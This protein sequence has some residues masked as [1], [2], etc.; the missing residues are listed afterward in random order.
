MR[1]TNLL[2][3]LGVVFA[4]L[5]NILVTSSANSENMM[6]P[7]DACV[8][9][10]PADNFN[11]LTVFG[12]AARA[13]T[14]REDSMQIIFFRFPADLAEPVSISIFDPDAG[15][16]YD[17]GSSQARCRTR[18]R[19]MGGQGAFSD[20]E[21]R[22]AHPRPEQPGVV[23]ADVSFDREYDNKWYSFGPFPA[24]DGELVGGYRYFKVFVHAVSGRQNNSFRLAAWPNTAEA[25]SYNW[26]FNLNREKG[27]IMHL[28]P[29]IP[30]GV[31]KVVMWSYDLDEGGGM[32]NLRTPWEDFAVPGSRSG[33]WKDRS[34]EVPVGEGGGRWDLEIVKG[35]QV[36]ANASFV[37]VDGDGNGLPIFT[38]GEMKREKPMPPPP[39]IVEAPP[40][41]VECQTF[42]FDGAKSYDPD[43]DNLEY[44]WDFGDGTTSS[45][46]RADHTFPG[47]GVYEV[48]LTVNDYSGGKCSTSKSKRMVRV[49][50]PPIAVA[51]VPGKGCVGEG[52]SLVAS[53]STDT[54]GDT[55]S[56]EWDFGDGTTGKGAKVSHS[57][58]KPGNYP[59]TLTVKDDS[60]TPCNTDF[61]QG[62]VSI[63]SAPLADAG[64]DQVI[65]IQPGETQAVVLFDGSKSYDEQGDVLSYKWN[66]GDNTEGQGMNPTHSYAQPG[67]YAVTLEVTDNS[68]TKCNKDTDKMQVKVNAPPKAVAV[69]PRSGCVG[70]ALKFDGSGSSD[71]PGD[72][73]TFTWDFGDGATATGPV[74][75]HSYDTGGVH[76]VVLTVTDSSGTECNYDVYESEVAINAPPVAQAG[77]NITMVMD[78]PDADLWVSFDGSGST[79]SDGNTLTYLWDFGD[80]SQGNGATVSHKYKTGGVYAVT[81]TVFDDSASAC[82][83]SVDK[84]QVRLN[85]APKAVAGKDRDVCLTEPVTLHAYKSYDKDGDALTYTWDLGDG[86]TADGRVVTHNYA[87]GGVYD[88][89]LTVDDGKGD[90]VSTAVDTL[91]VRVNSGPTARID[92]PSMA[93]AGQ[94]VTFDGS[95]SSDPEGDALTYRWDLGDGFT[96]SGARVAHAYDRGGT[97]SVQLSVNDG[98]G[99][100][101]SESGAK[102]SIKVNSAPIAI[103]G[104]DVICCAGDVNQ[105]DVSGSYDPDGDTLTYLWDFGDGKTS[106]EQKPKHTYE[107]GG[108]YTVTLTVTDGTDTAC[109][110]GK[111]SFTVDVNELPV[112]VIEV[113]M[114]K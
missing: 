34:I 92:G 43:N 31:S 91:S 49:N 17:Q 97:Y 94:K 55:L 28:W 81:L 4:L 40:K 111:D 6:G 18:V 41:V 65:C 7:A 54:P 57:Y 82:N 84:T 29:E 36:V 96:A 62:T 5:I 47:P 113:E 74:V 16:N 50:V 11:F 44:L 95:G 67:V 109:N 45:E 33:Q 58:S 98:S 32:L 61:A 106:T 59:I 83:K 71:T 42:A 102:T 72:D 60:G 104:H 112:S 66:F 48:V 64:E 12:P 2:R 38:S 76:P 53:A 25:F 19:I 24:S 85:R 13:E 51:K 110:T 99:L 79:D 89:V 101:C 27:S 63:N 77:D 90:P 22:S 70:E 80:G 75:T 100:S 39:R 8:V 69:I 37:V 20:P 93:C 23:L 86:S 26:S 68:G 3:T 108:N 105:L 107:N 88:V 73:L 15:G 35:N 30:A 103:A 10:G 114:V 14:G 21:S 46:I 9:P 1:S 52:V 78:D 56:Y 87:K